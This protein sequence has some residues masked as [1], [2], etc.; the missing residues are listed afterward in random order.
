M[1]QDDTSGQSDAE[2]LQP[3]KVV[4]RDPLEQLDAQRGG[5]ARDCPLPT[6][7]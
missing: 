7:C 5:S 1:S 3:E 6:L 4:Y 2:Y